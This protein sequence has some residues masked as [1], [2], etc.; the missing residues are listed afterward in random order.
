M[1]LSYSLHRIIATLGNWVVVGGCLRV[2][3]H[4]L[5]LG[6]QWLWIICLRSG[7]VSHCQ[8]HL[9][10]CISF[11]IQVKCATTRVRGE[12][13]F[14]NYTFL[15][16]VVNTEERPASDLFACLL[17][18]PV[19]LFLMPLQQ[20]QIVCC[21]RWVMSLFIKLVE[22][23]E[24]C[25]LRLCISRHCLTAILLKSSRGLSIKACF[26]SLRL[27]LTSFCWVEAA[28]TLFFVFLLNMDTWHTTQQVWGII[29]RRTIRSR[30][31]RHTRSGHWRTHLLPYSRQ[32][33]RN[34]FCSDMRFI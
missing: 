11:F 16:F 1:I 13:P 24:P 33:P 18:M 15:M 7:A 21:A 30:T 9:A 12:A 2:V 10:C 19:H 3:L 22:V 6:I 31:K 34:V 25:W 20:G 8:G 17:V 27:V 32:G 26:L 28:S 5:Q 23:E 14:T 29:W 4:V